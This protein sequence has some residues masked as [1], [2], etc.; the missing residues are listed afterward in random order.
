MPDQIENRIDGLRQR[1]P[2]IRLIEILSRA[3]SVVRQAKAPWLLIVLAM[4]GSMILSGC[5]LG[6]ASAI[7]Y[8]GDEPTAEKM[9]YL[10]QLN[11]KCLINVRTNKCREQRELALQNGMRFYH[12]KS[13]VMIPPTKK[14]ID[15]FV[16][17]LANPAN[18]PA[19]LFC[20]GGRDRSVFYIGLYRM[21]FEKWTAAQAKAEMK[22]HYIR[23]GWPIFWKYDDV[24]RENAEYIHQVSAKYHCKTIVTRNPDGYCPC[25]VIEDRSPRRWIGRSFRHK[26]KVTGDVHAM[27]EK[28]LTQ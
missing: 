3:L 9:V 23:R 24:L 4:S 15:K 13:G 20:N 10:K 16:Q 19:Y 18:Q 5:R 22:T 7:L 27:I 25:I 26:Q 17:I 12:V 14:E 6:K 28:C 8:W 2:F 11:I 1:K 21:A